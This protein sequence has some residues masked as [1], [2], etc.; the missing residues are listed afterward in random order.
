[1]VVLMEGKAL[2]EEI[3]GELR[4]RVEELKRRG[5]TP[6]LATLLVGDH[7]ASKMYV[8][9]K[10]RDCEEVGVSFRLH[11][12]PTSV[13]E[14]ELRELLRG[15]NA[16]EGV[17]GILLQLPVPPHLD[18]KRLVEEIS[19]RK[20]VDGLH[21][22]NVGRLWK[23]Q[24][25]PE[26]SLLPCTPR[27]ILKLLDRYGVEVGGS[28][29]VIINRSDLVGKPLAKLLL[30]RDASVLLCHSKTRNL[31]ERTREADVVVSAVGRRPS[32]VLTGEMIREGAVVVDVGMN[33]V[34]GKLMGDAD[35]EEVS[36][37]A[38][39]LAPVP[40]GVGPMTRA[41]LLYNTLLAS[42]GEGE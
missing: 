41:M 32:F 39:H 1:M 38:S 42:E 24:Y 23:G 3:K 34:G 6:T 11:H 8:E 5:I 25:D 7:P 36:R 22:Y 4:R 31:E 19:P 21:P 37:K 15:L 18:P 9:G 16:E 35:F 26:R 20:D 30:D 12:L 13:G 40:G 2:A 14:G 28:L 10:R 17:H 33:Y 29:V 27:G